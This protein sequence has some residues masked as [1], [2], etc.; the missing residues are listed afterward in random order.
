MASVAMLRQVCLLDTKPRIGYACALEFGPGPG[1]T[2]SKMCA[3]RA[4]AGGRES[5]RT[6]NNTMNE[7]GPASILC[8]VHLDTDVGACGAGAGK[9]S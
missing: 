3:I 5:A 1:P 6:N 9:P 2:L 8:T 7:P 4:Y